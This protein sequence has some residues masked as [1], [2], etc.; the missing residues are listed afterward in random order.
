MQRQESL[1]YNKP[2]NINWDLICWGSVEFQELK[3][4][5]FKQRQ[6]APVII[7]LWSI[8]EDKRRHQIL[9]IN[10]EFVY[11]IVREPLRPWHRPACSGLLTLFPVQWSQNCLVWVNWVKPPPARV[12]EHFE[13]AVSQINYIWMSGLT[14]GQNYFSRYSCFQC[15][16]FPLRFLVLRSVSVY[17]NI[18]WNWLVFNQ[19]ISI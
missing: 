4:H 5:P 1:F 12:K 9:C 14:L 11:S 10:E 7:Q 13:R 8:L 18:W 17:L 16:D 19:C 15:L 2:Y 6:P 3:F